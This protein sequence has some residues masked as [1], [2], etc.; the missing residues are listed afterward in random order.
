MNQAELAK[1][2]GWSPGRVN[3][4]LTGRTGWSAD[5]QHAVEELDGDMS[6]KTERS[7]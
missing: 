6:L 3:H 5:F 2:I 4:Q 1:R 7:M